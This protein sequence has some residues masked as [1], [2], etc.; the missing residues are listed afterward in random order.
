MGE[1]IGASAAQDTFYGGGLAVTVEE[2][3][4]GLGRY[5]MQR[6]H[7]EMQR[8][9]YRTATLHTSIENYRTHLLSTSLGYR[10]VDTTITFV[11]TL[12]S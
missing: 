4:K 1:R 12:N 9:G 11:K 2:R 3:R 7:W 6:M 8:K 10:V 5:L